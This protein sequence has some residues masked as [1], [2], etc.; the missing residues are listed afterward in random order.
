[1]ARRGFTILELLLALA[2]ASLAIGVIAGLYGIL[3]AANRNAGQRFDS[4]ARNTQSYEIMQ[5]TFTDL[6]AATPVL[7]GGSAG[8]GGGPSLDDLAAMLVGE[9]TDVEVDEPGEEAGGSLRARVAANTPVM[10]NLEWVEA[11]RDVVVQRLE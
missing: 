4:A 6:V 3:G 11:A 1:M 5:R 2:L 10:F 7:P 8:A 9:D